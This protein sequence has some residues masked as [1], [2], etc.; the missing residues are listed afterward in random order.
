MIVL[1]TDVLSLLQRERNPEN[2]RIYQRSKAI[3]VEVVTSIVTYEEQTRGWLAALGRANSLAR[4]IEIYSRLRRHLEN[5]RSI[6]V[7]DFDETAAAR[8]QALR[9]ARIRIGTMDLTIA[10]IARANDALLLTR[11]LTD[12][13]K[14]PGLR[15]EHWAA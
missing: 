4:Q 11:N 5:Y 8:F 2:H 12:F 3:E 13:G 6:R 10:A 7:L 9:K 1:D 15:V 14:V